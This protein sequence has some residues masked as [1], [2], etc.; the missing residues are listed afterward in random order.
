MEFSRFSNHPL[1]HYRSEYLEFPD[2]VK[3]DYSNRYTLKRQLRAF[4]RGGI[5]ATT[6]WD[7]NSRQFEFQGCK[8]VDLMKFKVEKFVSDY[9]PEVTDLWRQSMEK[10]VGIPPLHSFESQ[11][12]F[13]RENLAN[14]YDIDLVLENISGKTVSVLKTFFSPEIFALSLILISPGFV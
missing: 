4:Q 13:S 12:Y 5:L 6:D 9:A 3:V 8:E 1:N 14:N 11:V 2:E 10:A 7:I